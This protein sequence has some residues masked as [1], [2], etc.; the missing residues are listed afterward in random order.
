MLDFEFG[1]IAR[2]GSHVLPPS[3]GLFDYVAT[4]AARCTKN[5][6][7]HDCSS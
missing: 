2:E 1:R 6:E 5:D 3:E 4:D 7:F